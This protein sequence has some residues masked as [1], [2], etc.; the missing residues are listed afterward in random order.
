MWRDPRRDPDLGFLASKM[1][2]NK[3]L[4]V[5]PTICGTLMGLPEMTKAAELRRKEEGPRAGSTG[6]LPWNQRW[7]SSSLG[8]SSD[9]KVWPADKCRTRPSDTSQSLDP[10]WRP[11]QWREPKQPFFI[12]VDFCWVPTMWN[13]KAQMH[14]EKPKYVDGDFVYTWGWANRCNVKLLLHHVC[15]ENIPMTSQYIYS[16]IMTICETHQ[17]VLLS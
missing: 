12:Q 3:F 15:L 7:P 16:D 1:V 4:V 17:T 11:F 2:W 14:V 13:L 6:S 9:N 8:H 5:R 10:A